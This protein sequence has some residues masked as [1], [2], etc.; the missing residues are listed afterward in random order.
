MLVNRLEKRGAVDGIEGV[1]DVHLDECEA[2]VTME[3][4]TYACV[5]GKLTRSRP[6]W[7]ALVVKDRG[8]RT[9]EQTTTGIEQVA[10]CDRLPHASARSERFCTF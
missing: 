8:G 7:S 2:F 9:A 6:S 5:T 4:A 10:R 3:L 1:T